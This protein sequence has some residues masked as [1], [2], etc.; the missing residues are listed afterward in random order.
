M[1][2]G[3]FLFPDGWKGFGTFAGAGAIGEIEICVS[4]AAEC[5]ALVPGVLGVHSSDVPLLIKCQKAEQR[6]E[7]SGNM[8]QRTYAMEAVREEIIIPR[9]VLSSM[10]AGIILLEVETGENSD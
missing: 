7:E 6:Y 1:C 3:F 9:V 2:L 8:L 10:A 4:M 5:F